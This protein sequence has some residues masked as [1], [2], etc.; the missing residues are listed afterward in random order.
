MSFV[1]LP[2]TEEIMRT[3]RRTIGKLASEAGVGIETI[4]Y[5]ERRG[6][7]Q[8]PTRQDSAREYGDEALWRVRYIKAAQKW[9]LSLRALKSLLA[10]AELSS[11]FCASIR[12]AASERIVAI[13]KDMTSLATQ[14]AELTAFI[15]ACA[16]KSDEDRC[17]IFRRINAST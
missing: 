5:Y 11:N 12:V 16:S 9:G 3:A 7:L 1:A 13:D 14:R 17:P 8:Q 15:S 2:L 4:R 10:G 6:L